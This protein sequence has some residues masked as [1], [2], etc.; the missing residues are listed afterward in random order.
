MIGMFKRLIDRRRRKAKIAHLSSVRLKV[1]RQIARLMACHAHFSPSEYS[2]LLSMAYAL[3]AEAD[4][5][6]RE[7]Q[8][9]T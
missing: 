4:Q 8:E 1:E 5:T 6:I 9:L 7:L 2:E 3:R